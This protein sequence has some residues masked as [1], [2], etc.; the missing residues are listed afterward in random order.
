MKDMTRREQTIV[1]AAAILLSDYQKIQAGYTMGEG[2]IL[3]LDMVNQVMEEAPSQI[4]KHDL[5]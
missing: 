4:A 5:L 2:L 3:A 1:L